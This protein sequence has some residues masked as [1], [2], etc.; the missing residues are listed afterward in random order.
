MR[1]GLTGAQTGGGCAAAYP[2]PVLPPPPFR[3]PFTPPPLIGRIR[4][5]KG[6]KGSHRRS[7]DAVERAESP[8]GELPG[9]P[10]ERVP[11]MWLA[12]FKLPSAMHGVVGKSAT[13]VG[14]KAPAGRFDA[15]RSGRMD[16]AKTA[17][18]GVAQ[19]RHRRAGDRGR[20]V[21]RARCQ[22]ALRRA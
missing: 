5:K 11:G 9:N 19:F 7:V 10:L 16:Y 1:A 13:S 20:Q 15:A 8:Q 4:S 17:A 12:S 6:Q 3:G 21:A 22:A 14:L 18:T 2:P